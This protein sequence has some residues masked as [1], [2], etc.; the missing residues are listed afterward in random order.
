MG[1]SGQK[2]LIGQ[3]T[4]PTLVDEVTIYSRALSDEDVKELYGSYKSRT[5]NKK[6]Q[7]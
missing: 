1:N 2:F 5:P 3:T 7:L 6:G 4:E